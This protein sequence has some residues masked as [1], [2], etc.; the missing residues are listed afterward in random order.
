VI[1]LSLAFGN[2]DLLEPVGVG[3]LLRGLAAESQYRN[4]E[5]IDNSLRS[6]LFEVPKPGVDPS[7]CFEPIVNPN[8]FQGVVD[9]GAIDV[10]RG[11]DHGMPLY[12]AMR[13]AFGLAPKTSWSGSDA[14]RSASCSSR[15]GSGSSRRCGTATGSSTSTIRSSTS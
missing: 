2:P 6:V 1:P 3:P 11:R 8:C 9:L 14:R 7:Q 13:Q 12:N 5:Q 4:D 10:Q 15:S